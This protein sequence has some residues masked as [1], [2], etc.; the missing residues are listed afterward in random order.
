MKLSVSGERC[1]SAGLSDGVCAEG[2]GGFVSV[3]GAGEAE[4]ELLIGSFAFQFR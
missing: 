3:D 2:S 4:F 1:E